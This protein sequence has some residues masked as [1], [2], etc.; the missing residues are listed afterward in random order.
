MLDPRARRRL[1]GVRHLR[2]AG[3]VDSRHGGFVAHPS[4]DPG[5]VLWMPPLSV[6]VR[7][8]ALLCNGDGTGCRGTRCRRGIHGRRK[9]VRHLRLDVGLVGLFTHVVLPFFPSFF[10]ETN[11]NESARARGLLPGKKCVHRSTIGT[12]DAAG[13]PLGDRGRGHF[14]RPVSRG[15]RLE[16]EQ[17][18]K[19]LVTAP[20]I[21]LLPSDNAGKAGVKNF[22]TCPVS[23]PKGRMLRHQTAPGLGESRK[24]EGLPR[25]GQLQVASK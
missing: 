8:S 12:S 11:P 23:R 9:V 13:N 20:L 24:I 22:G 15:K 14:L 18:G 5:I 16:T 6:A 1:R 25:A 4:V 7:P 21:S 10:L 19:F 17:F 3:A 2:P